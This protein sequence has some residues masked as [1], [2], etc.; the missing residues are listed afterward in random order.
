MTPDPIAIPSI[1]EHRFA[2][3][4]S[5]EDLL[6]IQAEWD[7]L[8]IDA[9]AAY[10]LS[11]PFIYECWNTIHRPQGATLCCAVAYG[12]NRLLAVLPMVLQRRK[13]W[14]AATTGGPRAAENCDILIE[15][16]AQSQALARAL[17]EEFLKLSQP[18]FIEWE[19]VKAGSHLETAIQSTPSLRIIETVLEPIPYADLKAEVDW[20]SYIRSLSKSYRS[21]IARESRRLH[22]Q[23]KIA[24]DILKGAPAP[25]IDWLF[26][27]KRKWSERT[28]KR[29]DWVF[30]PHYQEFLNKLFASSPGFLVFVMKLDDAPIAVKLVAINSRSAN[31]V[32]IT[33]DDSYRRFSPGNVLDEFM[34]EYIFEN[35][36]DR[37]GRHLDLDFGPGLEHYKL[38]WSRGNALAS[39]SYHIASSRWGWARFRF[40]QAITRLRGFASRAA[41]AE[42]ARAADGRQAQVDGEGATAS[43]SQPKPLEALDISTL[44]AG[45]RSCRA[46]LGLRLMRPESECIEGLLLA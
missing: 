5:T 28:N 14:M 12:N 27:Q 23:G 3:I 44:R 42:D 33:Y 39:N 32:M 4:Q 25:M 21:K 29:G 45:S 11:F 10:F 30:S 16:S 36:L 35:Y 7:R 31:L 40:K 26:V 37:D 18:D 20:A 46:F 13:L 9:Q 38:H 2:I 43:R 34:M 24:V 6:S 41:V 1:V 17:L 22:E 8:W 19:F 15:R